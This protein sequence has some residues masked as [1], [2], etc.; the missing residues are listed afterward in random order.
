MSPW[1]DNHTN[2]PREGRGGRRKRRGEEEGRGGRRERRME[3]IGEEEGR[4][5]RG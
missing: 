4:G 2:A 3:R 5:R 1:E